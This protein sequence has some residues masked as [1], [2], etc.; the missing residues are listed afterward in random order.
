V[1]FLVSLTEQ[2][3]A[4]ATTLA[5]G[6]WLINTLSP[7]GYGAY[8][9]WASVAL[10]ANTVMGAV[11]TVHLF[12][13]LPGVANLAGRRDAERVLLAVTVLLV[14]LV[15]ALTLA[16]SLLL[17]R[18]LS[19]PTA[20]AYLAGFMIYQYARALAVSRGRVTLACALAAVVA[21]VIAAGLALGYALGGP[22][23]TAKAL[24]IVGLGYGLPGAAVLAQLSAGF[25]LSLRPAV[26]AGFKPYLAGTGWLLLG[27]G[28]SE[29]IIRFYSFVVA[30]WA[31]PAAL[32][33][34]AA[35]QTVIKP[36]WMLSMAWVSVG[37]PNLAI[38]CSRQD[39]A[40]LLGTIRQ[41]V[42]LTTAGSAL[43]SLVSVAVWPEFTA[44]LYHGR[45]SDAAGVVALWGANVVL[46]TIAS[47][48][49]IALQT[50]GAFRPLAWVDAGGAALTAAATVLFLARFDPPSCIVATL[51]G[52]AS[53]IAAMSVL[54]AGWPRQPALAAS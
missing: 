36:A 25:G 10:V 18:E 5:I 43:W 21:A 51:L 24:V 38:H 23:S 19:E 11:C 13:L 14:L 41:G 53:Q 29:V 7:A 50:I 1:R 27:A 52:Q 8:V 40:G 54:L 2:F 45:Y 48:M 46:G 42:M 12:P 34:L 49:N 9:F 33:R 47:P 16:G 44:L 17:G 22:A 6:I 20:S 32:G 15:A 39:R 30:G 3:L 28:S 26:L 37:R 4:S 35:T 31:G